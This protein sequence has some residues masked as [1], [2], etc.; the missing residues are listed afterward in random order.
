[1]DLSLLQFHQEQLEWNEEQEKKQ[2]KK[3]HFWS[4]RRCLQRN[5]HSLEQQELSRYTGRDESAPMHGI[6]ERK[7]LDPQCDCVVKDSTE[8]IKEVAQ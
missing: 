5:R 6:K 2:R 8:S 1:M 7:V 3:D 4:Q